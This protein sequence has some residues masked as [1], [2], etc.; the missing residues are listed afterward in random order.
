MALLASATSFNVAGGSSVEDK[1]FLMRFIASRKTFASDMAD[2]ERATMRQHVAYWTEQV[3]EGNALIFGPVIDPR[4]SW[5]FGVLKVA[6]EE[7]ALA[8]TEKDPAKGLGRYEVLPVP[9]LVR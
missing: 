2:A 5:G 3:H 7:A 9:L 1:F 4:E 6:S 8:L